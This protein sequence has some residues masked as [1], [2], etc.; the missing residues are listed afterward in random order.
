MCAR[1][2]SLSVRKP[3]AVKLAALV[4]RSGPFMAPWCT[5]HTSDLKLAYGNSAQ[6][7]F[8]LVRKYRTDSE[9]SSG[10]PES[11]PGVSAIT[12]TFA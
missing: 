7:S 9:A 6:G 4:C 2:L 8:A 5:V 11:H 3:L 12:R 1:A 10:V